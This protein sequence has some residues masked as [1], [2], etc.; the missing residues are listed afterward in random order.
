MGLLPMFLPD[1]S[2]GFHDAVFDACGKSLIY[3]EL[4]ELWC[5]LP[6]NVQNL[7][8]EWGFSDKVYEW[9]KIETAG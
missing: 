5:K 6:L 3:E 7:A 8:E 2:A 4:V 1:E 9:V